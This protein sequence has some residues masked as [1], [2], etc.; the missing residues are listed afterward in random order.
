MYKAAPF[1]RTSLRATHPAP[2]ATYLVPRTTHTN[3][4]PSYRQ[5]DSSAPVTKRSGPG[6]RA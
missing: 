1:T 5:P 4:R 6:V 3:L 2:Q